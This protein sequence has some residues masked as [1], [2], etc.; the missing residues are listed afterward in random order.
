MSGL[1]RSWKER[2]PERN[3]YFL[4]RSE[5]GTG[6]NMERKLASKGRSH[7]GEGRCRDGNPGIGQATERRWA[8]EGHSRPGEGKG[9]ESLRYQNYAS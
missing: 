6:Q 4:V 7:P 5:V 8:N 2:K 9:Q 3:T 1:V